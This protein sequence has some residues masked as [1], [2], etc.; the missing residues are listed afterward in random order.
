MTRKTSAKGFTLI[1]L[2][3]VIAIIAILASILFPVFARAREKARQATCASD[4]KQIGLAAHMYAQD[5]DG[6]LFWIRNPENPGA[7]PRWWEATEALAPYVS[8]SSTPKIAFDGC[9][10]NQNQY[11]DYFANGHII[12]YSTNAPAKCIDE[13]QYPSQKIIIAEAH[14]S[15]WSDVFWYY[16]LDSTTHASNWL[17]TPHNGGLNLLW[18]DGHVSWKRRES[19]SAGTRIKLGLLYADSAPTAL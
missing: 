11:G 17:E 14:T 19:L 18:A 8:G 1:E 9:P 10:S 5:Y 6:V 13:I 4:L 2:L 15:W 16:N 12:G 3:V 7:G